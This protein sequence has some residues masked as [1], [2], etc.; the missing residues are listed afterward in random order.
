MIFKNIFKNTKME[1]IIVLFKDQKP[2]FHKELLKFKVKKS[3]KKELFKICIKNHTKNSI[4][5]FLPTYNGG[6]EFFDKNSLTKFINKCVE[7]PTENTIPMLKLYTYYSHLVEKIS[8]IKLDDNFY[9]ENVLK[10]I[11]C[12]NSYKEIMAIISEK[13]SNN[14]KIIH[15]SKKIFLKELLDK[16]FFE[17]NDFI[18]IKYFVEILDVDP[19]IILRDSNISKEVEIFLYKNILYP[20][21]YDQTNYSEPFYFFKTACITDHSINDLSSLD[22]YFDNIKFVF[23]NLS[24]ANYYAKHDGNSFIDLIYYDL[25]NFSENEEGSE[26]EGSEE[27]S[28]EEESEGE[29]EEGSEEVDFLL[30]YNNNESKDLEVLL[31]RFVK[32]LIDEKI[33]NKKLVRKEL[34]EISR[35]I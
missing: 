15:L 8:A 19:I 25:V 24:N 14:K 33:F 7:N 6:I 30:N 29:S 26:G 17:L 22:D 3:D 18:L 13:P 9:K 12:I 4:P 1:E 31:K 34:L 35:K 20:D 23:N 28:E 27:E 32:L 5:L 2:N 21:K 11:E 10:Y 16:I